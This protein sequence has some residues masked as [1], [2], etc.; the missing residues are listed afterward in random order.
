M[1]LDPEDENPESDVLLQQTVHDTSHVSDKPMGNGS[2]EMAK[3]KKIVVSVPM[4]KP[5]NLS[6]FELQVD[7]IVPVRK[8]FKELKD[9][10]DEKNT[11]K[12]SKKRSDAKKKRKKEYSSR[13]EDR[14]KLE[15]FLG[16]SCGLVSPTREANEYEAL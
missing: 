1:D 5:T 6:E 8:D 9:L 7:K 10:E 13:D 15:E 3:D 14:R 4:V 12:S 11:K 2:M 16:P